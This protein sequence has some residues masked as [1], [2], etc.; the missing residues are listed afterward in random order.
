MYDQIV[1]CRAFHR[2]FS[3]ELASVQHCNA[4]LQDEYQIRCLQQHHVRTI[5][6]VGAHVGSFTL[7]C[8]HF[9]PQAR[10]IA[11]EPHPMSFALLEKNTAH[12]P[13]G[14]LLRIN[15]AI[16]PT[17]G[18]CLLASAVSH[19]RVGDYVVQIWEKLNP[20]YSEF[21]VLVPGITPPMLWGQAEAFGVSEIDLLKLD[22]EGAEYTIVESFA[23]EGRLPSVGWVRGEWHDA[24]QRNRLGLAL[25]RTHV[26]NIDRNEP[27]FCGLFIAHR[28]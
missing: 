6:D 7:M 11:V 14:Q 8:H 12:I 19:S 21:G 4:V 1:R 9:W 15:A 2:E 23:R 28:K 13:A 20:R 10:I 3:V 27:H 18:E 26:F 17:A 16:V 5:V 25:A 22:C 24:S